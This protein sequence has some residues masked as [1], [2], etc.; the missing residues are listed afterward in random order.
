MIMNI[1]EKA[2]NKVVLTPCKKSTLILPKSDFA[3]KKG[4]SSKTRVVTH[5]YTGMLEIDRGKPQV[6]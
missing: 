3:F 4:I 2:R 6:K 5:D 1:R